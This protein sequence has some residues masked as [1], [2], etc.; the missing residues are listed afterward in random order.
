MI[1]LLHFGAWLRQHPAPVMLPHRFA[2]YDHLNGDVLRN[3]PID[4]MEFGVWQGASIKHWRGQNSNPESRFYGFDSFEGLPE[5]WGHFSSVQPK[6]TF[7]TSGK[8]PD[9]AD[10]RVEFVTGFF[11]D[12]LPGFL[13][14]FTPKHRLVV[15]CDADLYSS[16]LYVLAS[17]DR[18]MRPG[19]IVVF[20][21]FSTAIDEFRAFMDYARSFR[22][23]YRVVAATVP[24]HAQLAVELG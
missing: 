23:T 15:H 8:T 19:T 24:N 3:A 6:G 9:I 5:A 11:Q 7:S 16:T 14:R 1:A 20:D 22:R 12:S 13:E 2:L 21:E 4:Y 17:L 18:V 10:P